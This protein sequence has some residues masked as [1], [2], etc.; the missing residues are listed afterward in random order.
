M[1]ILG[2]DSSTPKGS[3][4]LLENL[5][6]VKEKSL[7]NPLTYTD[8]L[9]EAVD[10]IL[11]DAHWNLDRVDG[12][13]VTTGPGSFTGLRVGVSLV[14]GFILSNGKPFIGVD[15]LEAVAHLAAPTDRPV[16]AILDARKQEVYS[17]TFKNSGSRLERISPDRVESPNQLCERI[18]EPTVFIGSGL[19]PYAEF[20][21][22]RLGSRFIQNTSTRYQTVAASAAM[23]AA[24][25]F[26]S[27]KKWDLD[28]LTIKYIRKSEA[29]NKFIENLPTMEALPDG[30]RQ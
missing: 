10:R 15:T 14:K 21:A 23:L 25:N 2:I 7:A 20:L 27:E 17:A 8:C 11:T 6:I 19:E 22:T 24:P 29:E 5:L 12:F 9:L 18:S 1:R 16:C 4:A 3:V 13:C 26:E 28:E 30:N